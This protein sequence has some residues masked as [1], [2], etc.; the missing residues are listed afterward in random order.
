LRIR[1]RTFFIPDPGSYIKRGMKSKNH[2]FS[3]FLWFQEEVVK[4]KKINNPELG[5][6][7]REKKLSR[8]REWDPGGKKS[9][10]SGSATLL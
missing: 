1:I 7:I 2:L 10:G 3:C 6:Q 4:V 8:I 9:I 5:S